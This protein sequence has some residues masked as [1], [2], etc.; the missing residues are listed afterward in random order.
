MAETCRS[1]SGVGPYRKAALRGFARTTVEPEG[2]AWLQNEAGEDIDLQW[3]ALF[4]KAQLGIPTAAEAQALLDRDPDPEAWVSRLQVSAAT[5]DAAEKKAVWQTLVTDRA[6]PLPSV[7][8]VAT[9]F[10]ST[11]QD[12]L[13]RPYA[14]AYLDL[15]PTIHRAG[16]VPATVFTRSLFPLFGIDLTFAARAEDLAAQAVPVVRTNLLERVDQMRRILRS[17]D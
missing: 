15:V 5:P 2:V 6:V 1:L 3:R 10:W 11:G 12:D 17:R 13:L 16:S 14:E 7:H 4:R 8:S 9:L